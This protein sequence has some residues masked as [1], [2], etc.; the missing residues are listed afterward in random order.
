MCRI[1]QTTLATV[2]ADPN[3]VLSCLAGI[4]NH[5]LKGGVWVKQ[6]FAAAPSAAVALLASLVG[7]GH[8]PRDKLSHR[9]AAR[10]HV[11]SPGPFFTSKNPKTGL[12][13]AP[14]PDLLLRKFHQVWPLDLLCSSLLSSTE[15]RKIITSLITQFYLGCRIH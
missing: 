5:W 8:D 14:G 3:P 12:I 13:F 9:M 10:T 15:G 6:K 1:Y 2:W 11:S 7:H 4:P